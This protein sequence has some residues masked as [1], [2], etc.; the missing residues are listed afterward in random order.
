VQ[1]AI[2]EVKVGRLQPPKP[3]IEPQARPKQGAVKGAGK[4]VKHGA[5]MSC[6]TKH[7]LGRVRNHAISLL[8]EVASILCDGRLV[9]FD[10]LRED[11]YL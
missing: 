3:T 6:G 2:R 7:N 11:I 5:E 10:G 9:T 1:H 4:S 8:R